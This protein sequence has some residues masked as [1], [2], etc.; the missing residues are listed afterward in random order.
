MLSGTSMSLV[1][2]FSE[3]MRLQRA[4]YQLASGDAAAARDT[5]EE[6]LT[7]YPN[8]GEARLLK[9]RVQNELDLRDA[10]LE[11]LAGVV[12]LWASADDDFLPL[13]Q[14]RDLAAEWGLAR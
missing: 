11:S 7:L 6:L 8:F 12:E 14:A 3:P 2:E 1:S 9:A 13:Q 10:A 5:L 4:Q